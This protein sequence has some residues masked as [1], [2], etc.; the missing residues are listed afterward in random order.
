MCVQRV[1]KKCIMRG[2]DKAESQSMDSI[3][4]ITRSRD[5][6][7]KSTR[8]PFKGKKSTGFLSVIFKAMAFKGYLDS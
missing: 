2:E 6:T 5:L 4:V 8:W 7:K 3:V 1:V